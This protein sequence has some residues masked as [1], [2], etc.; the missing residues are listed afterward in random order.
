MMEITARVEGHYEVL[1]TPFARSYNWQPGY[2]TLVCDCGQKL[3]LSA[4]STSSTCGK[5]GV[6]HSTV[7]PDI[8]E[9]ESQLRKKVRSPW[10]HDTQQQADQ[11]LRDEAAYP[12]GSPRRY[13]DVM[14]RTGESIR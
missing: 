3:G 7:I 13:N 12:V 2:V 10:R 11:Q 1:E 5:C 6:D 8:Q 14:S 4:T 9:R